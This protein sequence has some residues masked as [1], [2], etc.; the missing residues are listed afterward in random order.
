M[1][2][3]FFFFFEKG[4][5]ILVYY[6]TESLSLGRTCK[7][8]IEVVFFSSQRSCFCYSH[9]WIL[10]LGFGPSHLT[11]FSFFEQWSQHTCSVP[12]SSIGHYVILSLCYLDLLDLYGFPVLTSQFATFCTEIK[13]M[14]RYLQPHGSVNMWIHLIFPSCN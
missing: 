7:H 2:C 12:C 10:I 1:V 9:L 14:V 3:S 11:L 13:C 8:F 6:L 4:K 5:C